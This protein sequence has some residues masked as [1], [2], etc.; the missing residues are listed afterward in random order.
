MFQAYH[1]R[2]TKKEKHQF[3][4][5]YTESWLEISMNWFFSFNIERVSITTTAERHEKQ[6]I[7]ADKKGHFVKLH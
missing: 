1:D 5:K 2:F 6:P 7:F 4:E 3:F